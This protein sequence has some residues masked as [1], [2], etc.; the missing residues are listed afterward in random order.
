MVKLIALYRTPAEA[1]DFDQHLTSIHIP[2]LKEYPG[3]RRI[4]ITR[5]TQAPIGDAS[6]SVMAEMYFDD[7]VAMDRALSSRH[8]K[9][10]ARDLVA[11]AADLVTVFH[12][13]V[14]QK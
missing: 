6:F 12:G 4:E 5:I 9:A 11:F 8:G 1:S 7:H 14:A 3:L 2:P 13:E 10:V